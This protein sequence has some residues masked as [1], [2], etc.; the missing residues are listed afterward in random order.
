LPDFPRTAILSTMK[1]EEL[2]AIARARALASSGTARWLRLAAGLSLP[3][4]ARAVGVSPSTIWRWERD[5]RSPRGDAAARYS[6]LL[7]E[8]A[9]R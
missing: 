9:R 2:V 3:E 4:V 6:R 5:R 7:E 8:L 1:T